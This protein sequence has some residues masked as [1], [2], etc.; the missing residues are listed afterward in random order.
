MKDEEIILAW[1]AACRAAST[2]FGLV[3][4]MTPPNGCGCKTRLE[5]FERSVKGFSLQI[6]AACHVPREPS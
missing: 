4:E 5:C 1:G 3:L 2:L 6:E